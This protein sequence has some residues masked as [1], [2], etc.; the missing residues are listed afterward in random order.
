VRPCTWADMRRLAALDDTHLAGA[1]IRER[2]RPLEDVV[3]LVGVED[4][5]DLV[6][7]SEPAARRH[8]VD[9]H[10]HTLARDIPGVGD[11]A[12]GVVAPD[13]PDRVA[14]AN[15]PCLMHAPE[16]GRLMRVR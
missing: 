11:L 6:A 13:G 8:R 10:V 1:G 7:A 3:E 16:Y 2:E 4:S 12:H 14:L 5:P 9:E 15:H